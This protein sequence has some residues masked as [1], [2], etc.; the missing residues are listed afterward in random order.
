MARNPVPLTVGGQ[1][2]RIVASV[3]DEELRRLAGIVDDRIQA[4]VRPGKPVPPSAILLA[5]IALAHDLEEERG[6]RLAVE[7][8]SRDVLRRLLARIDDA[9]DTAEDGAIEESPEGTPAPP[10]MV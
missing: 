3:P 9:L 8:R 7:A 4:L 6:K 2:Y 10:T 5:A 1:S